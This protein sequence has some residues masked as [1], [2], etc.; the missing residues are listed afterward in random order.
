M[1][2]RYP[3]QERFHIGNGVDGD[4]HLADLAARL[5]RIGIVAQLRRQIEGHG[6]PGRATLEQIAVAGVGFG[7][8]GEAGV[9]PHRPQTPAIHVLA[10]TA[11]EGERARL[12]LV[13]SRSLDAAV[14]AL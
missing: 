4:A 11:R 7:G 9:L 6:E 1:V 14:C 10:G 3:V 13:V 8:G 12:S 5:R 2:Q